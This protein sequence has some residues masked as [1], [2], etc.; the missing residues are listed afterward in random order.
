MEF[1]IKFYSNLDLDIKN[2]LVYNYDDKKKT[3][4]K[5]ISINIEPK[6]YKT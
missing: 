4:Y 1:L 2:E 6:K 5:I 3:L